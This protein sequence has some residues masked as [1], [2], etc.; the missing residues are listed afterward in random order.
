MISLNTQKTFLALY[1][2]FGGSGMVQKYFRVYDDFFNKQ[3]DYLEIIIISAWA[4]LGR[5]F[6]SL[7]V[8][9]IKKMHNH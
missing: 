8:N 2:L 9:G 5:L 7:L 3:L 6:F 4:E 1:E